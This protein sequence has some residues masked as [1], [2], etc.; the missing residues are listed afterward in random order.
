MRAATECQVRWLIRRDMPEVMDIERVSFEFP[1]EESEFLEQLKQRNII[2]MVAEH[3]ERVVGFV[4][5]RLVK[6]KIH[7]LNFAVAPW[8]RRQSV[9]SQMVEKLILKLSYQRRNEIVLEVRESN[10]PAQ[11][12]FRHCG[13]YADVGILYGH[14]EDTDEDAYRMR[15]ILPECL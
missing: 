12:F 14:Y 10:L 9:G 6:G 11:L 3:Q 5:Y 13:F 4:I 15:Y 7:I 8:A 1:W 2:G